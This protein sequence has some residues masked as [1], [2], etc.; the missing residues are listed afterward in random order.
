MTSPVLK[1][2][3]EGFITDPLDL[4]PEFGSF[5]LKQKKKCDQYHSDPEEF[6][7]CNSGG[8]E[9]VLPARTCEQQEIDEA[10]EYW[11]PRAGKV[12]VEKLIGSLICFDLSNAYLSSYAGASDEGTLELGF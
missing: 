7:R 4:K 11:L 8:D 5:V 6:A 12:T 9:V 2:E 3:Y 10:T 1:P